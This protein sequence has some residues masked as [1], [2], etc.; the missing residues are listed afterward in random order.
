[1]M[2]ISR[3]ETPPPCPAA[4]GISSLSGDAFIQKQRR[5]GGCAHVRCYFNQVQH[6]LVSAY[7]LRSPYS[8]RRPSRPNAGRDAHRIVA[9][10]TPRSRGR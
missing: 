10:A 8:G 6:T 1:M 3:S 2:R 4:I 5:C 7:K 9:P